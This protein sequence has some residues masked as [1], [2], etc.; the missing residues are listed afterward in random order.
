MRH[1]NAGYIEIKDGSTWRIFDAENWGRN[2]QKLLCQ[3]L[4]FEEDDDFLR[5]NIAS[6]QNVATGDLMFYNKTQSG[7]G[8]TSCCADLQRST[9]TSKTSVPNARCKYSLYIDGGCTHFTRHHIRRLYGNN[10]QLSKVH[11]LALIPMNLSIM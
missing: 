7:G 10:P 11:N 8:G 5:T 9:T 2:H 6:G 1:T 3:H 4:G